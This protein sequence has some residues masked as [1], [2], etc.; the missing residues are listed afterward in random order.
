MPLSSNGEQKDKQEKKSKEEM[1][2]APKTDSPDIEIP[3]VLPPAIAEA[4][5]KAPPEVKQAITQM[6][7]FSATGP[8][9]PPMHPLLNKLSPDQITKVL[10]YMRD[11]EKDTIKL[12]SSGRWFHLGYAI[13]TIA[14]LVFLIVF[15]KDSKDILFDVIK[16]IV[17]LAGAVAGGYGLKTHLDR[18]R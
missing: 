18:K 4:L 9:M 11:S 15:L 2:V 7:M 1:Q 10:D 3:E 16:T 13:L 5:K 17:A 14:F 6:S 8:M 12:H